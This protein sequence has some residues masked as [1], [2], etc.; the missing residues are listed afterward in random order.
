VI[1]TMHAM[2]KEKPELNTSS[3]D[4]SHGRLAAD[5]TQDPPTSESGSGTSYYIRSFVD[6]MNDN[7]LCRDVTFDTQT[8]GLIK[9]EDNLALFILQSYSDSDLDGNG[10]GSIWCCT[11]YHK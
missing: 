2:F 3:Q 11:E 4:T 6:P 5:N 8:R 10:V 1:D 7:Q 9:L